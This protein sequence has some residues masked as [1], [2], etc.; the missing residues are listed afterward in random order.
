MALKVQSDK[1]GELK[2]VWDDILYIYIF[3]SSR[4]SPVVAVQTRSV[5][6]T[7]HC[8]EIDLYVS[9]SSCEG[10]QCGIGQCALFSPMPQVKP[11]RSDRSKPGIICKLVKT[12]NANICTT[13]NLAKH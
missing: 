10:L 5:E 4:K 12:D 8:H 2:I 1:N 7:I 9:T 13:Y 3:T 11:I 6:R